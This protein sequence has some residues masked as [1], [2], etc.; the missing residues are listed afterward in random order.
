MI[1][2]HFLFVC[3]RKRE[4]KSPQWDIDGKTKLTGVITPYNRNRCVALQNL[5]NL[6]L[7]F[8][9]SLDFFLCLLFFIIVI[10]SFAILTYQL[11]SIYIA[12][13]RLNKNGKQALTLQQQ[14]LNY[15]HQLAWA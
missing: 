13:R 8:G 14:F 12:K 4:G 5:S 7:A 2:A 10:F 11:I 1:S 3:E 6:V 9:L 15:E